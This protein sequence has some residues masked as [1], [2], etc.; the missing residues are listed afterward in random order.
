MARVARVGGRVRTGWSAGCGRARFKFAQGRQ[1]IA[2]VVGKSATFDEH[3]RTKKEQ[4][5]H[6][7]F[8]PVNLGRFRPQPHA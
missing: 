2:H 5:A 4:G 3:L 8:L 6:L 7:A 1:L